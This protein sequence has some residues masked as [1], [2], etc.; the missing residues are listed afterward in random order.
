MRGSRQSERRGKSEEEGEPIRR[1]PMEQRAAPARGTSRGNDAEG[2]DSRLVTLLEAAKSGRYRA[3]A[4]RRVYIPKANGEPRPLGIPT[5]EDKVLQRAVVMVLETVYE[6]E[7]LECS[8][9][10]RPGRWAQQG[11]EAFREA[12]IK[13]AGGWQVELE[14]RKCFETIDHAQL[15]QVLSQRVGDG[16]IK[17]LV[18]KWLNA[19]VMEDGALQRSEAGTP[20]GGVISPLLANIYLHEVLDVWFEQQVR[21]RMKGRVWLYRY[22]DDAVMLFETEEDAERVMQVLP[23]RFGKYGLPLHPE[24]TRQVHFKRPDRRQER[25][26]GDEGGASPRTFDFLGFTMHWGKSLKGKWIVRTRTAKDRYR[27]AL[28]RIAQWCQGH[29]HE[30]I[31][32][33]QKML[34]LKL[35]GHY[36]YYGRLSNGSQVWAMLKRVI[37]AWKRALQR[38]SQRG[39]NWR[40]MNRLLKRFPLLT[41][42]QVRPVT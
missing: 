34:N 19:G 35:R 25:D 8:Y 9:G 18:G 12:A 21:P 14:V 2:Q 6:Q 26:D 5:L 16:E 33:Q 17:R 15:Q 27:R 4:V 32:W 40:K 39:L 13:M 7:F 20:Q 30:P 36:G 10:F 29:R 3:P 37:R 42:F 31:A 1:D 11:L 41:P 28:K 24:K 38:R 22:A 23:K